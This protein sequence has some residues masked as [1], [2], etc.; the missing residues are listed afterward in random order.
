MRIYEMN[1]REIMDEITDDG[2]EYQTVYDVV[3]YAITQVETGDLETLRPVLSKA[4][5][6]VNEKLSQLGNEARELGFDKWLERG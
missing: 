5:V 2:A 3:R 1:H 6:V 4:S